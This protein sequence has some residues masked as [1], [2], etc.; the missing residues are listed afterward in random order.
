MVSKTNQH[1]TSTYS[2][3]YFDII[4]DEKLQQEGTLTGGYGT[5]QYRLCDDG[6][7]IFDTAFL[8]SGFSP[9]PDSANIGYPKT[10]NGM[11]VTEIHYNFIIDS[12]YPIVIEGGQIKRAF[13]QI[14]RRT[15]RDD[16]NEFGA[17]TAFFIQMMKEHDVIQQNDKFL[18]ITLSF[19]HSWET[20]EYCEIKTDQKCIL[21]QYCGK[22]L[23]VIS[24]TTVLANN[25]PTNIERASFSGN[26]YPYVQSDWDDWSN[27]YYF[28]GCN[29]LKSVEGSLRGKEGWSFRNCT[30]LEKVHLSE[31]ITIVPSHAF[32]NCEKIQDIYIPDSVTEIGEYAFAGCVNLQ[33]IHLPSTIR[34]INKGV[35]KNCKSLAK[36]YLADS[37]ERIE[38]EAFAG[39]DSLRK[40]WMP[41]SITY[42]GEHAFDRPEW[43]VINKQ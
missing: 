41:K 15:V 43:T 18:D 35:F 38:D 23:K 37:I 7:A 39:C 27:I 10:I 5:L 40:P 4:T 28:A 12:T 21:R 6:I 16:I 32:E 13:I 17:Y 42:I 9:G 30:S 3:S 24:P 11:P 36:C 26:V 20:V 22:Y 14:A 31:G 8:G 34:R 25:P 2:G 1:K 29:K 19:V 33:T